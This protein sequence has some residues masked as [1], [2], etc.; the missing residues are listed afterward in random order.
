VAP[1]LSYRLTPRHAIGISPQLG[2]QQFRGYGFQAFEPLSKHPRDVTNNGYE[3]AFG[4]GVRVG[5]FAEV[6]PWLDL[7][8][9]YA[10][11]IWFEPFDEYRGFFADGGRFDIPANFAVGLALK[12]RNLT[13]AV[14]VQRIFFGDI[15]ALANPVTNTLR[16]P[17]R[18]GFGDSDGSG[19]NWRHQT[20]YR[21]S[22]TWHATSRLDLRA[23]FA[24]GRRPIADGQVE[25]V[26]FNM[27][28]PSP[29]LNLNAGFS[30][31]WRPEIELHMAYGRYARGE[32]EGPSAVF[33]GAREKI[34]PHVDTLY[35]A[36][37][38]RW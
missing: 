10:T 9:S 11:K 32:F 35:M 29:K 12:D 38:R 14:D 18:S 6:L 20:N 5:W 2:F 25:T 31:R 37:T 4:A 7:G 3:R 16:D 24:Y 21:A 26:S 28:A 15:P 13:L 1:T 23:G 17:V 36:W 22:L 27:F 19:F 33:P 30:W 8:A 34:E